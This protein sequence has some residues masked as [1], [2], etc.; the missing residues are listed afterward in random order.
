M[1]SANDGSPVLVKDVATVETS[2]EPRLGIAGQD[3][4]D[5]IV[6]G[7]VLMRRGEQTTPTIHRVEAEMDK[8]NI[9]GILPA[10]VRLERIYDRSGLIGLT[11]EKVVR[12]LI[13]GVCLV[14]AVQ[15]LFLG[16]LRSAIVVS[17]TIPFALSFAIIILTFMGESA[18]LLSVGAIDFGLVVVATVILVENIF[19]R[20]AEAVRAHPSD[21]FAGL[22]APGGF[23]GKLAA[24]ALAIREVDRAVLFSALIIVTGFVPLFTLSGIEGHI[25]APM[26]KTYAYAIVGAVI[27]TFTIAPA[28]S[29]LL[30]PDRF[31]ESDT[32]VIRTL[33][34][35]Y[36]PVLRFSLANRLVALGL[37]VWLVVVAAFAAWTLGL[38]FLPHLEEGNLWIRAT[39]PQSI[40]LEEAN[41]AVN[42]MRKTILS[43]PEVETVISQHGRPQDGTDATGFFNAEFFAP[44]KPPSQWPPRIHKDDIIERINDEL[45]VQFPGVSFN[46][47]QYIEDNV[48]EAASGV[49]GENSVK[50]FGPDLGTLEQL[51]TKIRAAMWEVKGIVDLAI[52]DSLGQVTLDIDID[53]DRA[54][55]HGLAIGDIAPVIQAGIGGQQAGTV[56]EPGGDQN[57]PIVVRLAPQYRGSVDAIRNLVLSVANP[58]GSGSIQIP[59]SEVARVSLRSG[60][61][62]I[63]RENEERYVPIKFGVRK[64]DLAGAVREAQR[65]VAEEVALPPGYRIEWVGAFGDLAAA[66]ERLKVVV[67]LSIGAVLLL[68]LAYF[69]SLIDMALAASAMPLALIG[70]IFALAINGTPFSVSAAIG[71]IGLF[72]ISVMEGIIILSYFNRRVETGLSREDAPVDAAKARLR[73]VMM[74]CIAACVGLLPA[75]FSYGVGAQVQRPLAIVVVGGNLLSP[76]LIL[77]VLPVLIDALSRKGRMSESAGANP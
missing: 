25:F 9:S 49:K 6:Q 46:F 69:R 61:S 71:F 10:G 41:G 22:H 29:A 33:R 34:Q 58:G 67:P 16:D 39:M 59:L 19:R 8:I 50:L 30:L 1:L 28:L 11:T 5:D 20:L 73:P 68:L 37:L 77:V 13:L 57:F 15:W 21:P 53:R 23:A 56:F 40:S 38:E 32:L 12:N 76:I 75:A 70:G 18:N 65:K 66:L 44:L 42:R 24:I 14:F 54:A 60:P 35:Y 64:R 27:A 63:Y 2:Y 74:T 26:A 36:L 17:A 4:D 51:A 43:F 62:M 52:F 31:K 3:D 47:S 72:G 45:R 7:I 55:R 48:E